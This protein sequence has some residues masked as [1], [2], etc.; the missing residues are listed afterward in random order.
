[1]TF[2]Y[3]KGCDCFEQKISIGSGLSGSES[4]L[5]VDVLKNLQRKEK[6]FKDLIALYQEKLDKNKQQLKDLEHK[7]ASLQQKFS[8]CNLRTSFQ[9]PIERAERD[10]RTLQEEKSEHLKKLAQIASYRG[11]AVNLKDSV[12]TI[13]DAKIA[14]KMKYISTINIDMYLFRSYQSDYERQQR[15][16]G[17]EERDM[18][19][20]KKRCENELMVVQ[21]LILHELNS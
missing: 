4:D 13:L 12:I 3:Q 17:Y 7:Y 14:Q 20:E 19:R 1:M 8:G 2:F 18:G 16:H 11:T 15:H 6:E 5:P 10:V 21:E 9:E